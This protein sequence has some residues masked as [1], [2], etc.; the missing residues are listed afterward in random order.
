MTAVGTGHDRAVA[1]CVFM[2]LH[3]YCHRVPGPRLLGFA[4]TPASS[5]R[6]TYH[7]IL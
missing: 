3:L 5:R 2:L 4:V 7:L 1:A 6:V